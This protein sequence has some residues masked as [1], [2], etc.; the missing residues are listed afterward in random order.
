M[1]IASAVFVLNIFFARRTR[2]GHQT[3]VSNVT[4]HSIFTTK[5]ECFQSSGPTPR[6]HLYTVEIKYVCVS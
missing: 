4:S 6:M 5:I 3:R 1:N 2:S